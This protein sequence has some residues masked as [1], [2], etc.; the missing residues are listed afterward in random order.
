MMAG[1]GTTIAGDKSLEWTR[2]DCFAIPNW[3]W[4]EHINRSKTEEAILFSVNDTPIVS[5]LGLYREEPEHSLHTMQAPQ[6]PDAAAA[7]TIV[8]SSLSS[9]VLTGV[10][11]PGLAQRPL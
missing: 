3:A 6:V 7:L 8:P 9:P 10:E 4:H 2:H 5:A 11:S 1:D